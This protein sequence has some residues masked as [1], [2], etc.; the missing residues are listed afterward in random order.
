ME[1]YF[2]NLPLQHQEQDDIPQRYH[3][4]LNVS[5]PFRYFHGKIIHFWLAAGDA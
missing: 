3:R 2:Q 1:K 4:E 5:I